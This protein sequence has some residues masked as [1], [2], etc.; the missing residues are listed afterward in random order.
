LKLEN[1]SQRQALTLANRIVIKI[2]SRILVERT[3]KPDIPRIRAIVK[4]IARLH[5]TKKEI[6]LVSSGAIAAGIETLGINTRP[7]TLPQLQMAAAV[8]QVRL[9]SIYDKYFSGEGCRIGQVLLT[10]DDLKNRT[11]HLNA[12]NT[13]LELIRQNIIPVVNENDVV[14]VDE[15]KFGDNDMLASLVTILI[16]AEALVLLTTADGLHTSYGTESARRVA[17]IRSITSETLQLA[18]RKTS[19]LSLGGME[20]KLQSAEAAIHVGARVVIADGRKK[21]IITRVFR[22]EDTGTLIGGSAQEKRSSMKGRKR[23]IAFFHK[24]DGTLIIDDGAQR[25]IE[26]NGHSLL[27][28]GIRKIEGHFS[29]GALVNMKSLKGKLIARGLVDYSSERL[30]KIKGH[31][32]SEII[33]ILGYKDYE[34]VIHRDNMVVILKKSGEN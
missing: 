16:E 29:K 8:G 14:S 32:T 7:N 4:E 22:G 24:T 11:R 20:S 3:G 34:E 1:L 30:A 18:R 33:G 26:K 13:M 21:Q 15:I 25:A 10:H 9:I 5:H 28:I 2:G 19:K 6:V 27:A 31:K 17:Y 23:W 12:R